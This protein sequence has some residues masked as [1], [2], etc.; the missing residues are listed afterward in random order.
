MRRWNSPGGSIELAQAAC[1]GLAR[2]IAQQSRFP[3]AIAWANL[4]VE[5]SSRSAASYRVLGDIWRQAGHPDEAARAYRRG[6]ARDP[7]DRWLRRRLR[8]LD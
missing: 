2:A 7:R 5:R 8:E 6:L 4:A 1:E 3:E